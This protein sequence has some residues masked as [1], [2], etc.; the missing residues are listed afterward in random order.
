MVQAT[1][2]AS[3]SRSGNPF[4]PTLP[5]IRG[6]YKVTAAKKVL[7]TGASGF[8]GRPLVTAL[9]RDG[10]TV[11]AAT[12]RPELLPSPIEVA[13]V[14][15]FGNPIDWRPILQDIDIVVHLAGFAHAD[16]RDAPFAAFDTINWIAT[17]KLA[18][19]AKEAGVER[20]VYVSSVRAQ[21]GSS[22]GSIV[23]EA[24][25]SKPSDHYGRSK[26]AAEA[27]VRAAGLPFT[28]LRPVVIYG[29]D[30]RGNMKT[31]VR[32]ASSALPLPFAGFNN[33]RS[34]LGIDNFISAVLFVLGN[35]AT[36]GETF[37][38]ADSAP[39]SLREVWAMLRK[40]L[41][42]HPGLFY[43]PPT[44][45]RLI[46]ILAN[47]EQLWQRLGE[48]LVVDTSKLESFGWRPVIDTREGLAAMIRA[49]HQE[50]AHGELAEP[51]K[52]VVA[53]RS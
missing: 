39:V 12:R 28:I 26:R 37:L 18:Q 35:P 50:S 15:D 23:S 43:V 47:R 44:L 8:I 32:L 49:A 9:F 30:P 31:L 27:E 3:G 13:V 21:V 2:L 16:Y 48:E 33:R 42:R 1:G 51:P 52:S 20:F 6:G 29:P 36:K 14:P 10:Y 11:R 4:F 45:F 34:L 5:S 46:L 40:P 53:P 22:S 7:V 38:V 17:A 41:R 19:A 24:G 25:E